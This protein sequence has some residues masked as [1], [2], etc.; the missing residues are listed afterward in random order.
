MRGTDGPSTSY[1]KKRKK[2][3]GFSFFFYFFKNFLQ[4]K[5]TTLVV[6]LY[7]YKGTESNQLEFKAGDIISIVKKDESGWWDGLCQGQRG[8]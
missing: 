4:M 6:A 1:K 2:I 5:K 7:D 8:W 3:P